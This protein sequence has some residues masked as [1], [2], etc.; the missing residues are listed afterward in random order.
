MS[1][2]IECTDVFW[3]NVIMD[4]FHSVYQ[5]QDKCYVGPALEIEKVI[6]IAQYFWLDIAYNYLNIFKNFIHSYLH[7]LI[8]QIKNII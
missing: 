3:F 8:Q 6:K 2:L 5:R 4:F 1:A 7:V